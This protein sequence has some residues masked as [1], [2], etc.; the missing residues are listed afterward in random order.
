ME[1][2][3][4]GYGKLTFP[5]GDTYEGH[6]EKDMYNGL[7]TLTTNGEVKNGTWM[8]GTFIKPDKSDDE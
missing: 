1:N 6:F 3:K 5:N 2:L 7:G 8:R 4:E